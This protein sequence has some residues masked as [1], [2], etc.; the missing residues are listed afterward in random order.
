MKT[1]K[2]III[3][4]AAAAAILTACIAWSK[5]LSSR[6]EKQVR[7]LYALSVPQSD[8]HFN[9][10]Q[11]SGLPEP[12]QRYFRHVLKE[13]QAYISYARLKHDGKFKTGL[14]EDWVNITG[15]QNFTTATP[16]YIWKGRTSKFTAI[17]Q[18]VAGSGKL[19]A[20]LMS[21]FRIVQ[22]SGKHYD[23]GELLRWLSESVWFPTNLLPGE[24]MKWSA[25]NDHTA[26][27]TFHHLH[28]SLSLVVTFDEADEIVQMEAQRYMDEDNLE[29][30]VTRMSDY[31]E[32]NGILVP[33]SAEA[34]WRLKSGDFSY[35]KF[36]VKN[37]EY[38]VAEKYQ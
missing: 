26:K 19:E 27:V 15:E 31:K 11:L 37:I 14:K 34:L 1:K 10:T 33:T 28:L 7:A 9:H 25:I 18:Y 2:L 32:L 35:A 30:W 12:V 22:G 21:L 13:G 38:D 24:S 36:N 5:V 16:G 4:V 29:T 3:P 8:K 17:D 23:Q 6:F 20:Y